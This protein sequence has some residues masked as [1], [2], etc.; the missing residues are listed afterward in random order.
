MDIGQLV[1]KYRLQA[2]V[3]VTRP[4]MPR[5]DDYQRLLEEIW[6]SK[7]LTNCGKFHA[8][9]EKELSSYLGVEYVNLFCNGT[10]ALL[11]ALQML[12]ITGGEVI[13]TPFTF[14]AT[15]HVLYWNNLTPVF[16]DIEKDTFNMDAGR[17]ESLITP[18]TK[19]ILPVHVFG[20]P[21]NIEAIQ[22]IAD[23]HGLKVIYDAA[24]AFGVSYKGKSIT[25]FGDVSMLSFHATK[26]FSSIEGG[27]LVPKTMSQRN[28]VNFLKNFGIVNEETVI[29]PGINGKMNELQAAYGLLQLKIVDAEIAN[30]KRLTQ[31][32]RERLKNIPGIS[33]QDEMPFV[34]HNY[35]H[36]AITV[37]QE[38]FGLSRDGLYEKLKLFNIVPRKYF[39]PLCSHFACYS[40][41]PSAN[42]ENLPV[43][44]ETAEKVLC[45]PLYGTLGDGPIEII[46]EVIREIQ[47]LA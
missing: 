30:R 45:L 4:T 24:H 14:P 22:E 3:L 1:Q 12:E 47:R 36:F 26:L 7:W 37:D 44:E 9:F 6:E 13:T 34:T 40:G 5:L 23:R 32:Y 15:C 25:Q 2:P 29:G 46:C 38:L 10:I 18:E 28:R 20:N 42:K 16:C 8:E 33:F 17:I 41:L 35:S 31:L 27:A 21:C 43:A 19:A 11:V 39:Y